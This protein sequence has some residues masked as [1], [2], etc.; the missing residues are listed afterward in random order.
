MDAVFPVVFD[1]PDAVDEFE[2]GRAGLFAFLAVVVMKRDGAGLRLA[3]VEDGDVGRGSHEYLS[4]DYADF[5][6]FLKK[7]SKNNIQISIGFP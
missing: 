3:I 2:H 4:A 6:R 5:R 1:C 7:K